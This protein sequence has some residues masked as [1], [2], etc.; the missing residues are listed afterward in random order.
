M[1]KPTQAKQVKLTASLIAREKRLIGE[2]LQLLSARYGA[3]DYLCAPLIFD[4]TNYYEEEMGRPLYR[5]QAAFETLVRPESLPEIKLYSNQVEGLFALNGKRRLNI[6]PGYI[7]CPHLIL[8]TGKGYAHRPYLRDG[9]YADLTL[10]YKKNGFE[11]LPWTYP[12]Y[13]EETALK[14]FGKIRERYLLQVK[15]AQ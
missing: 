6:D 10:I 8:A 15:A 12:D 5:R 2:A 7:G 1:S 14:I 11:K 4:Y 9:I 13:A 3:V